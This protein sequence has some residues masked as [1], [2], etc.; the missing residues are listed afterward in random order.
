M[1][2]NRA[3]FRSLPHLPMMYICAPKE[4]IYVCVCDPVVSDK[5]ESWQILRLLVLLEDVGCTGG[6]VQQVL[7]FEHE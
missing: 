7:H 4:A 1:K 6:N 2:R 3:E 5:V